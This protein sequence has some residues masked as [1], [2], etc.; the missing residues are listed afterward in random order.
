VLIIYDYDSHSILAETMKNRSAQEHVRA[1]N[2]RYHYLCARGFR[3]LLQ[4]LDNEASTLLKNQMRLHNIDFQLVPPNMHRRNAAERAIRTFKKHFVAILATT[5]PDFPIRLWSKVVPQAVLTLNLLRSSRLNPRLSAYEHL[6]GTF[7]LNRIPF[8]PLGTTVILHE[9]P[10]QRRNWAPHGLEGW[11]V[12]PALEHYQCYRT[13]V[14]KTGKTRISDTVAFPPKVVPLPLTSSADAAMRA[15][16][17]LIHTLE[18]PVPAAPFS[19]L[20]SQ[21]TQALQQLADIFENQC[22]RDT[23]ATHVKLPRVAKT[24]QPTAPA[25][26]EP[27]HPPTP[28]P[29]PPNPPTPHP[30]QQP[31]EPKRR[32]PGMP[33]VLTHRYPTRQNTVQVSHVATIHHSYLAQ[34]RTW[35]H[36]ALQALLAQV[37]SPWTVRNFQPDVCN[38]VLDP[39]TGQKLEYRHLLQRPESADMWTRSFA[40]E[41]GRLAQGI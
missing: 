12:G 34:T 13:Y 18:H 24:I 22:L 4:K 6:E 29:P 20:G 7:D 15:A 41:V 30:R 38:H 28:T 19:Q 11:Y 9:K 21:Q 17:D 8:A 5:D 2:K 39:D 31:V 26:N 1:Y 32:K 10:N 16:R 40:N 25:T 37:N 35:T 3:P 27:P 14:I 23:Q 33:N 36:T